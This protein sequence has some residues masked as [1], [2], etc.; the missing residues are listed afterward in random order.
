[1]FRDKKITT[2]LAGVKAMPA[3]R[4]VN[5]TKDKYEE[6]FS[7]YARHL[8]TDYADENQRLSNQIAS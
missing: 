1:M 4:L 6:E 5:I 7:Q 8:K 2:L 3:E